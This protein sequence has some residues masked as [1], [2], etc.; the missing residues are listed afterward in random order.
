MSLK[1]QREFAACLFGS[2]NFIANEKHRNVEA[3]SHL[4]FMRE[5]MKQANCRLSAV[6]KS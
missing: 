2:K 6:Y 3:R 4:H 5:R 1:Y